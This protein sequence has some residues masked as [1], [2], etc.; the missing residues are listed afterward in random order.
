[1]GL[2]FI[3]IHQRLD[4]FVVLMLQVT[5]IGYRWLA[6]AVALGLHPTLARRFIARR[7]N[8]ANES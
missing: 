1:L 7:F 6:E 5:G 2:I 8:S 4:L 3:N